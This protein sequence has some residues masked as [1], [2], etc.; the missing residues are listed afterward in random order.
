MVE[1]IPTE[2]SLTDKIVL[3]ENAD[4]GHDWLFTHDIA[5]LIT[6]WGG[7]NSHMAIRANE[8]RLPAIIGAG[9]ILYRKWSTSNVIF[10][11]C[12]NRIV[13]VIS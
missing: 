7:A 9:E 10:I 2:N 13:E 11:D 5:G 8:L 1:Q 6:A 12:A 4:P 3:I